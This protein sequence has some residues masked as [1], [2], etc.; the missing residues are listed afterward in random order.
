[1]P[2]PCSSLPVEMQKRWTLLPLLLPLLLALLVLPTARAQDSLVYYAV[3]LTSLTITEGE[4]P[5][6]E[7]DWRKLGWRDGAMPYAALDGGGEAYLNLSTLDRWQGNYAT[8]LRGSMLCLH[9]PGGKEIKGTLVLPSPKEKRMVYLR[10]SVPATTP[11]ARKV[12]FATAKRSF[13]EHLL[14]RGFTGAGWW[15]QRI[16]QIAGKRDVEWNTRIFSGRRSFSRDDTYELMSG[17]RALAENLQLR[18]GI[19]AGK[20]AAEVV[21]LAEIEGITVKEFDWKE[22]LTDAKWEADPL[23]ARIPADQYALFFPS[24]KSM[25]DAMDSADLGGTL[26]AQMAES[27]AQDARTRERYETQL[28]LQTSVL[29]RMFGPQLVDSVAFTG[30]DPFVREGTDV[31]ILFQAKDAAALDTLLRANRTK[32]AAGTGIEVTA[33]TTDRDGVQV[34]SLLSTDRRVSSYQVR[35]G[36]TIVVTNSPAQLDRLLAVDRKQATAMA[37]LDEYRFFRTRYKRGAENETAYLMV[38]D[39]AIRRWSGPRWRIAMSRRVRAAAAMAELEAE[40]VRELAMGE[41]GAGLLPNDFP[42]IDAGRLSLTPQGVKSSIYGRSRFL[43]PIAEL[44]FDHVTEAEAAGYRNW[45]RR[46]QSGWTNAFDP[47]GIQFRVTDKSM[48]LDVTVMPLILGS[49]YRRWIRA[50]GKSKIQPTSGDPHPESL[51]EFIFAFDYESEAGQMFQGVFNSWPGIKPR[52]NPLSWVGQTVS[53]YAD[54]S[55]FWAELARA[56]DADKFMQKNVYRFPGAISIDVRNPLIAAAFL[57][58]VKIMA[59]QFAPNMLKW[60]GRK[61]GGIEYTRIEASEEANGLMDV[62]NLAV[63]YTVIKGRLVITLSEETLK[64]AIDR[65]LAE[66]P[67]ER[68]RPWL[69]EHLALNAHRDVLRLMDGFQSEGRTF[70]DEVRSLSWR[71]IQIL[72]E[73]R[74]MFDGEDAVAMHEHISGMRLVCSGG[75]KYVWNEKWITYESTVFG[76]PG[77]PK[78]GPEDI[79]PFPG[80]THG[81]FGVTFEADGVR[82]RASISKE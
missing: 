31:A 19:Q 26:M 50:V 24:F 10:F 72:N 18:R 76:H 62:D 29:A 41:T 28:G 3:P 15:R 59:A 73:W 81:N 78:H 53:I 82:A 35:L 36:D 66:K 54:R 49:D 70:R 12:D 37:E 20:R 9:V 61:H 32:N 74:R 2:L 21:V 38:T 14:A 4:I 71:N 34:H 47:I 57:G 65:R 52:S 80:W 51:F 8:T 16:R 5:D 11:V 1:M 68:V 64:Q 46:Y 23:A 42:D 44:K 40:H 45:H 48:E 39:G 55:P 79:F 60:T 6:G 63:H 7:D 67:I 30:G 43:T 13:Y 69:G 25:L 22:F 58:G 27:S 17:G 56:E 33:A 75:G 77:E